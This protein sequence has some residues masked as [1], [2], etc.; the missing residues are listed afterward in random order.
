[1]NL[2]RTGSCIVLW[3]CFAGA[4]ELVREEDK[5]NTAK[6]RDSLN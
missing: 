5:L 1:V 4:G 6:Y 2:Y 3:G